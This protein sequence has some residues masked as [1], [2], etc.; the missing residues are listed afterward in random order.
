MMEKVRSVHH[1][2]L[3]AL[4]V[5]SIRGDHNN[6]PYQPSLVRWIQCEN[7][8]TSYRLHSVALLFEVTTSIAQGVNTRN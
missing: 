6:R 1:F 7:A 8:I 3:S 5:T 4:C 2:L